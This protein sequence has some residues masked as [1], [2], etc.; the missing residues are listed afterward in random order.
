MGFL[1]ALLH[2]TP[3][4]L[5]TATALLPGL[6][7]QA[8]PHI[9]A[10]I[11]AAETIPGANGPQKLDAAVAIATAS[12]SAAQAAGAPIDAV[13]LADALPAAVNA[14]VKV[15]NDV[16]RAKPSLDTGRAVATV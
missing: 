14:V 6:H 11:H 10:A 16:K 1:W 15:V 5:Q 12:L 2:L 13:A 7:P 9:I 3:L 4:L 8:V